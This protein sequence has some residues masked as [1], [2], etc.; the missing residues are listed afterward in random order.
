MYLFGYKRFGDK[1]LYGDFVSLL[2][3]ISELL[4]LLNIM[5]EVLRL[6]YLKKY[7]SL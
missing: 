4:N 1:V 7:R 2:F 6:S 5:V 3:A